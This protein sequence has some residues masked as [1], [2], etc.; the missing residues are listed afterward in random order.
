ML[1]EGCKRLIAEVKRRDL[2]ERGAAKL[3]GV[4]CAAMH[5]YLK[6]GRTPAGEALFRIAKAFDIDPRLFFVTAT[7]ES[8][9]R[10]SRTA[11]A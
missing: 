11:A 3:V 6:D 10:S 1:S 4:S 2:T 5:R 9:K 7:R 8:R